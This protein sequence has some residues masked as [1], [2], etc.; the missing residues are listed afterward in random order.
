LKTIASIGAAAFM[1]VGAAATAAAGQGE[2][3]LDRGAEPRAAIAG[4]AW[5]EAVVRL[6]GR[7]SKR[8]NPR[9]N[10]A[11]PPAIRQSPAPLEQIVQARA[12]HLARLDGSEAVVRP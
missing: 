1:L 2:L 4:C 12:Y 7:E 10:A 3:C 5:A 8:H 11:L 6:Q 9:S